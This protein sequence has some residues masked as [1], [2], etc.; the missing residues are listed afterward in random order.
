MI[1]FR[2]VITRVKT[3]KN[4]RLLEQSGFALI[5]MQL[6]SELLDQL[7]CADDHWV[8]IGGTSQPDNFVVLCELHFITTWMSRAD[9]LAFLAHLTAFHFATSVDTGFVCLGSTT[10]GR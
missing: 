10:F 1:D 3:S 6:R 4:R 5:K 9:V 2:Q 7:R 8:H